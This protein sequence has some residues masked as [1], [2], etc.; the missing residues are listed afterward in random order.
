MYH[1]C[2]DCLVGS[3]LKKGIN[4]YLGDLIDVLESTLEFVVAISEM[5]IKATD[6]RFSPE[7]QVSSFRQTAILQK[8]RRQRNKKLKRV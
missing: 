8:D 7:M 2:M 4:S 1:V 5:V 6:P 3:V